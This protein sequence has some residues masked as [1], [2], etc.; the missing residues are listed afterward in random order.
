MSLRFARGTG[1]SS[2]FARRAGG[3]C[4]LL[5]LAGCGGAV[6]VDP[7]SPE[8]SAAAACRALAG[9]LPQVLDGAERTESDPPSPYVAVWGAGEIGLRCG[10]PR[11][12]NMAATDQVPVVDDVAWFAD[13]ARPALFTAIGR[14]AY[15]EV[16]ISR[17]HAPESVL[18]ELAVP[19]KA[20]L[21]QTG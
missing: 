9:R 18:V 12:A 4:A 19:V 8:P 11:P 15:V 1:R 20:A 16:T 2:R 21:P 13:P 14:A 17:A 6:R 7:P 10:V 5:A 3:V